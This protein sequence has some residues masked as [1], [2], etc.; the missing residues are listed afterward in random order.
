[1][2]LC[3]QDLVTVFRQHFERNVN[4][5]NLGLLID[6]YI[7]RTDLAIVRELDPNKKKVGPL[8]VRELEPNKKK[9]GPLVIREVGPNKKK[10]GFGG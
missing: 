2:E 9:V 5:T 8:V 6:A 7:R 1:M 3:S 10:M 4:A